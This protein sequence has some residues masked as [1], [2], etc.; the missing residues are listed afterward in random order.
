MNEV[1]ES[2]NDPAVNSCRLNAVQLLG[3]FTT[4][5]AAPAKRCEKRCGDQKFPET[6]AKITRGI[7]SL[8]P[9]FQGLPSCAAYGFPV[10]LLSAAAT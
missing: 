4:R 6:A 8:L 3:T 2:I 9:T 7:F 1:G 5:L 10:S